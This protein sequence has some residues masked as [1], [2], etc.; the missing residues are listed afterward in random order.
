MEVIRIANIR[1]LPSAVGMQLVYAENLEEL[2]KKY[3]DV[4]KQPCEYA[5]AFEKSSNVYY[6]VTPKH[7][8]ICKDIVREKKML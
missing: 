1:E 7:N 6:T 3:Q 8:A 2:Q 4:H 5:F